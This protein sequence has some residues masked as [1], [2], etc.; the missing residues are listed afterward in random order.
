MICEL[1]QYTVKKKFLF[2]KF[3][4][5]GVADLWKGSSPIL[6]FQYICL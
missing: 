1:N 5:S 3:Q 6:M 4:L 2:I